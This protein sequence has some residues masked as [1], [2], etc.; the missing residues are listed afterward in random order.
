MAGEVPSLLLGKTIKH[1]YLL[2]KLPM[3]EVQKLIGNLSHANPR[4]GQECQYEECWPVAIRL[5][6]N[7]HLPV[8]PTYP[9]RANFCLSHISSVTSSPNVLWKVTKKYL[10]NIIA[11]CPIFPTGCDSFFQADSNFGSLISLT[12][13]GEQVF[14]GWENI[15]N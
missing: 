15:E 10:G 13:V 8:S 2:S 4:V 1:V 6:G 11:T 14:D 9:N 7:W 12:I 5:I 3:S